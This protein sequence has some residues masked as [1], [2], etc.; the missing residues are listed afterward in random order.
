[1]SN[2]ASCSPHVCVAPLFERP[3]ACARGRKIASARV[4]RD[5]L[6]ETLA[7]GFPQAAIAARNGQPTLV[8]SLHMVDR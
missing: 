7:T 8:H 2:D 6:D 3:M 1:M 5:V 4:G